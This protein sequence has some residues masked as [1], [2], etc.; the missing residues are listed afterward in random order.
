MKTLPAKLK[1]WSN[2]L[3]IK[4]LAKQFADADIF[5][6]G[7][8]VRDLLLG[9]ATKD[10]DLVIRNVSKPQLEKFLS[11]RGKVNL[12]G[13]KFGVFKFVPKGWTGAEIDIALPRTE[14]SINGSGRYKDFKISSNAKLKIEDDLGRRDFTIN[15][16]AFD[17]KNKNLVDP[18][19]GLTDLKKKNIK[20]VGDATT[21]F[22]EDYS[23]MLRAIRFSC[24]LDFTIEHQ[25]WSAIKARSKNLTENISGKPI[26]PY[27]VVAKELNKS[28]VADPLRTIDL[29]DKSGALKLLMPELLKMKNCPQPAKWHSEGDCWIHTMMAIKN[30][31]SPKF[32]TEFKNEPVS[33]E[34]IWATLFH[35][36]GKP[37]TITRTDRI[38]FNNHDNVSAQKWRAIAERL[39][40]SSAGLDV[41][42]VEKTI[43]KHMLPANVKSS[44]MK[45]VTIEKYFFNDNFPGQ[46]LMMLMFTDILATIPQKTRRPDITQYR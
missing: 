9:H 7:G 29:L 18:Y 5:L 38:R 11:S 12:V 32:K 22:K 39:K 25:T 10:F 15:A 4:Q 26:V 14:H 44:T 17:L 37:Y 43:T 35:D 21:R 30:L 28:M 19:N 8:A 31:Y 16:L 42:R 24:Q 20:A 27:E 33:P 46:E 1:N 13:K 41:E 45:D 2:Q 6:V 36:L 23:R 34:L 40:L 3:F